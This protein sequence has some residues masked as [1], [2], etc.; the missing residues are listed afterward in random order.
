M[1]ISRNLS[2][3]G[4]NASSN[5]TVSITSGTSQASTSG[6]SI[7]FTGIPSWVKKITVMFNGVSSN[8]SSAKLIQLG[9]S[10]GVQTTSYNSAS[11]YMGASSAFSS[12]TTGIGINSIGAANIIHG[13]IIFSLQNT[14]DNT[15]VAQG[16]LA[17]SDAAYN[18]ITAGS[19]TLSALLTTIRITTTNGTDAFDAGSVNILYE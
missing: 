16:T 8:G 15:W 12:F 9:T 7:D 1:T 18:L 14:S 3:V 4:T 17:L 11:G 19:K 13:S 10:G 5:G 6:T 2:L